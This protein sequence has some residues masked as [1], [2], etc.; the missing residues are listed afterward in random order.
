M[1][2]ERRLV[3]QIGADLVRQSIDKAGW[4]IGVHNFAEGL[5]ESELHIQDC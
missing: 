5:N 4:E 1:D 3:K 2:V